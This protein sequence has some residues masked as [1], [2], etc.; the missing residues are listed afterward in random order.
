MDTMSL[1]NLVSTF[2]DKR[3]NTGQN[4]FRLVLRNFNHSAKD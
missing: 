3:G 2:A 4:E 1:V